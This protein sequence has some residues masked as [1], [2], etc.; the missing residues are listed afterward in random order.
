MKEV[1]KLLSTTPANGKGFKSRNQPFV[2]RTMSPEDA[3]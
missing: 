2:A 3:Q 1:R